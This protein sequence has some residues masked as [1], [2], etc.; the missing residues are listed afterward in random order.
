MIW[1][2]ITPLWAHYDDV[3]EDS[4]LTP[5]CNGFD[6]PSEKFERERRDTDASYFEL[7]FFLASHVSPAF[8]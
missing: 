8:D 7:Y 4:R 3:I 1:S 2:R 5:H 6:R